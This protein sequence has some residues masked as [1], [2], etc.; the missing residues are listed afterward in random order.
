MVFVPVM[1]LVEREQAPVLVAPVLGAVVVVA[2]D[3]AATKLVE[4]VL[5]EVVKGA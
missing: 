2:A 1:V 3:H 5:E 4:A